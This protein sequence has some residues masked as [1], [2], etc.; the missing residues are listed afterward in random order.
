M[1]VPKNLSPPPSPSRILSHPSANGE[2]QYAV[3]RRL[4]AGLETHKSCTRVSRPAA[5]FWELVEARGRL[6]LR[7]KCDVTGPECARGQ[8]A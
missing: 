3:P 7:P 4:A 1:I 5:R 8:L 6:G 2:A